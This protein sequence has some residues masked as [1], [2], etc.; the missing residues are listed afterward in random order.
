[1]AQNRSKTRKIDLDMLGFAKKLT[2][3]VL[4]FLGISHSFRSF[5]SPSYRFR[6][7][8][9]SFGDGLASGIRKRN[10]S[11]ET[12]WEYINKP[13]TQEFIKKCENVNRQNFPTL[14]FDDED[15]EQ[16]DGVI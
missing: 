9:K 12:F 7:F 16:V 5:Y 2:E 8:G 6:N 15:T 11:G 1:M 4:Y 10:E 13:E 14:Y 3:A